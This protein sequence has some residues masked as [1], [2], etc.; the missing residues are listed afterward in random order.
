MPNN[1]LIPQPEK[2][3]LSLEQL[4]GQ[5]HVPTPR[6]VL[7]YAADGLELTVYRGSVR[8]R[9]M[10]LDL[11]VDGLPRGAA[12]ALF[13]DKNDPF[14]VVHGPFTLHYADAF[15][16][17]ALGETLANRLWFDPQVEAQLRWQHQLPNPEKSELFVDTAE[18]LTVRTEHIVITGAEVERF[19][20]NRAFKDDPR[21]RQRLVSHA[22]YSPPTA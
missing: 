10:Q 15:D 7:L 9:I 18:P 14:T 11:G 6:D 21:R 22:A 16:L 5:W 19:E 1:S 12:R 20:K 3:Y 2:R 17:Y 4:A 13:M 8:G